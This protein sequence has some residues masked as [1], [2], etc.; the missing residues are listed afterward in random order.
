MF[1][2]F[3]SSVGDVYLKAKPQESGLTQRKGQQKT[4]NRKFSDQPRS[5]HENP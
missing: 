1:F 4:Q 5:T 3:L 2:P